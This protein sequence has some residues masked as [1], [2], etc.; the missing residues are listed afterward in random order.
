MNT[1]TNHFQLAMYWWRSSGLLLLALWALGFLIWPL[2]MEASGFAVIDS[3]SIGLGASFGLFMVLAAWIGI[4]MEIT[5][6]LA[7]VKSFPRLDS[8]YVVLA[9]FA[10]VVPIVVLRQHVIAMPALIV[11][12]MSVLGFVLPRLFKQKIGRGVLSAHRTEGVAGD[13]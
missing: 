1:S 5:I 10:L 4:L 2:A 12:I 3:R 11:S 8:H 13:A 6:W 9:L 7:L